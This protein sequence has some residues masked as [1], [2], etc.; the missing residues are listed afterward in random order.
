MSIGIVGVG[1]L[2]SYLVE[3]WSRAGLAHEVLLSPLGRVHVQSTEADF[4]TATCMAMHYGW[5]LG[6]VAE[7]AGWLRQQGMPATQAFALAADATRAA[8]CIALD[9]GSRLPDEVAGITRPG[10]YTGLGWDRPGEHGVPAAWR[11][12]CEAVL[13]ASREPRD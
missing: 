4:E 3:G 7:A 12:A 8:A 9:R 5:V 6:I 11:E 10:T 13:A 2:A 1:H